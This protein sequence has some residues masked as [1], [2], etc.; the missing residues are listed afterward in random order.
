MTVYDYSGCFTWRLV[1]YVRRRSSS[2]PRPRHDVNG[3]SINMD[4]CE[5]EVCS[6]SA[7]NQALEAQMWWRTLAQLELRNSQRHE[8]WLVAVELI[9]TLTKRVLLGP[10]R[11]G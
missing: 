2:A 11:I 1:T 4:L 9:Q 5:A 8:K 6:D 3:P 7:A 10:H